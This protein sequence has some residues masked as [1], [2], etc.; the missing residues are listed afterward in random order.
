MRTAAVF[1]L[2]AFITDQNELAQ[3]HISHVNQAIGAK[4]APMHLLEAS[5]VV[6][7][8]IVNALQSLV[9]Y[10]D[11]SFVDVACRFGNHPGKSTST[12]SC[13]SHLFLSRSRTRIAPECERAR[14]AF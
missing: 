12:Y 1:A 5:P 2:S 4:L 8:E 9:E 11:S 13:E 7:A 6:R 14:V 3:D 10:Y